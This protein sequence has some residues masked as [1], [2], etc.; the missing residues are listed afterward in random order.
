MRAFMSAV[1]VMVMLSSCAC[2]SQTETKDASNSPDYAAAKQEF[3]QLKA[4]WQ[5]E[6]PL[7]SSDSRDY[8]KGG[9][10]L[11]IIDGGK[12]FLPFVMAEI[13]NG[14]FFFNVAAKEITGISMHKEG[15]FQSEQEY[16]RRWAEWWKTNRSNPGWNIYPEP[17]G[18]PGK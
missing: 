13:D 5:Q 7:G 12:R 16:T 8:W 1:C 17:G 9:A 14:N 18:Q 11:Q 2:P 4:Q 10:G 6:A 3:V 15:E